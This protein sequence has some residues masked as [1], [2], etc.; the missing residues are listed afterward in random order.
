MDT[1]TPCWRGI[2]TVSLKTYSWLTP[3]C[4]PDL[5]IAAPTRLALSPNCRETWLKRTLLGRAGLSSVWAISSS[6]C[7]FRAAGTTWKR[8]VL[9]RIACLKMFWA[10]EV[11]KKKMKPLEHDKRYNYAIIV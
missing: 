2:H 4:G 8:M 5:G 1:T 7:L 6:Y 10:L 11:M 3:G 9:P